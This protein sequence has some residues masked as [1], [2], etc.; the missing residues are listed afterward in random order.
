MNAPP[1]PPTTSK[2]T[3][4]SSASVSVPITVSTIADDLPSPAS[5]PTPPTIASASLKRTA[6]GSAGN[7]KKHVEPLPELSKEVKSAYAIVA[8]LANQES[9]EN[10]ARFPATIK[11]PLL[12]CARKALV[13]RSTG[14]ILEE[15]FFAHL[16]VVLPYNRFTLKKLIYKNILPGWIQELETQKEQSIEMFAKRI[17]SSMG[18]KP[19]G[20]G[21][22]LLGLGSGSG[23][24]SGGFGSGSGTGSGITATTATEAGS[25]M[26]EQG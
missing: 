21:S 17:H 13:N 19:L 22:G 18:R 8:D 3:K 12:D 10:K 23:S 2:L 14:Y 9:W 24:G 5:T 1:P 15:S 20:L 4:I 16:Q 26:Q 6:S 7:E 25:G 11:G